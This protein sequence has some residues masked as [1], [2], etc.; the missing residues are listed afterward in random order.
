MSQNLRTIVFAAV[1]AVSVVGA[2][3][4]SGM[5]A[6]KPLDKFA[7]VGEKFY[8]DFD[9][10]SAGLLELTAIPE[11][12]TKPRKFSVEF[13]DGLWRIKS[14]HGYPAE[15]KQRLGE[16]AASVIG[17]ERI[18]LAGGKAKQER[19]GVLDP[20]QK[21]LPNPKAA[22]AR[23]RILD[24]SKNTLVDLIIGKRAGEDALKTQAKTKDRGDAAKP[25]RYVRRPD[26]QETYL[27]RIELNVSTKFSDW[28]EPDLLKLD[29]GDLRKLAI[30]NYEVRQKRVAI[31]GGLFMQRSVG[32]DLGTLTLSRE[33]QWD[34]W[35]LQGL[36]EKTESLNTDKIGDVIAVLDDMKILGVS[37]RWRPEGDAH[38]PLTGD[39]QLRPPKSIAGDVDAVNQLILNV[40]QDLQDKGFALSFDPKDAERAEELLKTRGAIPAKL[41]SQN[42]DV[43]ATTKDGVVYHLHFGA[44][45][46]GAGKELELGGK[47]K[48][49]SKGTGKKSRRKI[50]A[51]KPDALP[52]DET[53]RRYVLIR[54]EFDEKTM[55]NRPKMP[56]KPVEPKKPPG[57]K[58]P[59]KKKPRKEMKEPEAPPVPALKPGE[60]P[61]PAVAARPNPD[62]HYRYE[63]QKYK[64][65][66]RQYETDLTRYRDDK[67]AFD[68]RVEKSKGIVER[69][70]ERFAGWYYV[71]STQSL[72]QLKLTRDK[73]VGPKEKEKP[74]TS[75]FPGL[76]F[77]GM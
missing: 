5:T 75:K 25:L 27:A 24:K 73:L 68:K 63:A 4:V 11:G 34:P 76:K 39:L 17:V 30:H 71:V 55:D 62:A 15:A 44:I 53:H 42:G 29:A 26:E 10:D 45:V 74:P 20:G 57:Y 28:I 32:V 47:A 37:P 49:E 41:L 64:D 13:S 8:D 23:I 67:K 65:D 1:A 50:G 19:F 59:P 43:A 2:V 52:I 16:T 46:E 60:S 36:D 12:E 22:G 69:L 61:P 21:D 58:E 77:P 14:H 33:Q 40:R 18:A 51:K 35:K 54:V 6:A 31:G 9:I 56:T 72:L 70:N 7:R 66:I 38:A 3:L 48:K